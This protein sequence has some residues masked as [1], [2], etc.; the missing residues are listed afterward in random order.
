MRPRSASR[1]PGPV[2]RV[3]RDGK[4][5]PAQEI[6]APRNKP[7]TRLEHPRK[8]R[9]VDAFDDADLTQAASELRRSFDIVSEGGGAFRKGGIGRI[10][11]CSP[12]VHRR[13]L[14][15]RRIK[16]VAKRGAQ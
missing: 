4:A 16:V 9:P 15:D 13:G 3:S 7:L 14:T 2:R 8:A 6:A 10:D 11:G 5:V 1:P 12:P